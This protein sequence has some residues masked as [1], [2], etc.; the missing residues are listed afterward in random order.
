ML[1]SGG[2][3]AALKLARPLIDRAEAADGTPPVSDQALL[4]VSQ[5]QR[6]MVVFAEHG[7]EVVDPAG[8][9]TG[10][11][12][13]VAIGIIGQGEL[14]LV[15]DPGARGRG[16]GTAALDRLLEQTNGEVLAWAHGDNPEANDLL[17]RA[18]F[19][20]VRSLFRMTLDTALLPDGDADPFS[21]EFPEGF[22]LRTYGT[23]PLDDEAWVRTNAIAFAD[24]PEQGRVTVADFALMRAEP[25][26][27]AADLFLLEAP[28]S[29][30]G[31]AA[32]PAKLAGSTW[33]KTLRGGEGDGDSADGDSSDAVTET[34]LYAI[35]VD[36]AYAGKGLGR[37]LLEVTLAR[38][39]QHSPGRVTLYVDGENERAVNMYLA[40]GFTVDSRS[41]QWRRVP[42]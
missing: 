14:D 27:D 30:G 39:A 26:F 16:I 19:T 37:A 10:E 32:A 21:V 42:E 8:T 7:A 22:E 36:P 11:T 18:G 5:G 28:E 33:V 20:P 13:P 6:K 23:D 25:W 34:E 40:A 1:D 12:L 35:G 41:Q 38:M 3:D 31:T 4:A 15:V 29:G 17:D 9:A 2:T 24:H